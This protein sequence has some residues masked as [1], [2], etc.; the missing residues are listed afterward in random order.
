[1]KTIQTKVLISAA[2]T[3]ASVSYIKHLRE[4]GYYVIGI[5]SES[6][7]IG[8][9]LCDE[10]YQSPLVT[11][12][13]NF[14]L[15]IEKLTFDVYLPWLDEEHLLF[16]SELNISFNHKILTSPSESIN[17]SVDKAKTY[18]FAKNN[19]INVAE[20]TEKVPAFVRMNFSRGSKGARKVTSQNELDNLDKNKYIVQNLI[21]GVEYTI[22][23]LCDMNGIP[24]VIVP[25]E[26]V[27]AANVSLIGK[28]CMDNEIINFCKSILEKIKFFGPINIQVMKSENKLFLIEINP[29]LAG[30][31]ILTINSG[32]DVLV[33]G[34]ELFLGNDDRTSKYEVK[35]GLMMY[36][37]Y[38][39]FYS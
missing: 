39:E 33:D 16:A 21:E 15:F 29:R 13:D 14:L 8:K 1:M 26:R 37:F 19:L 31:S 36:R 5:N 28:V 35:D 18:L 24:R 38:D 4:K 17:I 23:C 22:D 34:I 3:L 6:N 11:D 20:K 30:T 12:K 2:G 32:A 10:Y 7:T 27:S 9:F 25:R